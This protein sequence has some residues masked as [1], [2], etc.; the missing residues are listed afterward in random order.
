[1]RNTGLTVVQ[2][3]SEEENHH[4]QKPL[5]FGIIRRLFRYTRAYAL[6]RNTLLV[7]VL[8]RS[9]QLPV[10]TWMIGAIIDGPITGSNLGGTLVAIG[11]F[12][13]FS[14][15]TQFTFVYRQRLALH[16]G[17]SVVHDLRNELFDKM[18]TMPMSFFDRT[19]VGRVISRFTTDTESVRVGVQDTLFVSLV[20]GG[21]MLI[22]AALMLYFDPLLF[23]VVMAVGPAIWRINRFF[24]KRLSKA[25]RDALESWSRVSATVAESVK[26]VKVSQSHARLDVNAALFRDL[27]ADHGVYNMRTGRLT[28]AFLPL[29]EFNSQFFI[30]AL[31]ILGG[32]RVLLPENAMPIG[33]LIQF[34]FLSNLFFGPIQSLAN[35]YNNALTAMVG[36]ER[37]FRFLDAE[38]EW[39]D[40][41]DA[42]SLPELRGDVQFQDVHFAYT[43]D[44]SALNGISFHARQG[45]TVALVGHTG[46]GK[47]T[48]INLISKFYLPTA[49][50]VL[51]DGVDIRELSAGWIHQNLGIVLQQNF[52]FT[53]TVMDNIR[54]GRPGASDEEVVEAVRRLDAMDF[55]AE[56]PEG[57]QTHVGEDGSGISIGQRQVVCFARA[58]L[59]DPRILILDEATSAIDVLTEHRLQHAL[60]RLLQDR[61]SFVIA[62]R[63][64]T[65]RYADLLLMLD[66]G[67]I[68]EKGSHDELM[69][70]DG[71]YAALYRQFIHARK[72]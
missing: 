10:M 6:T 24:R 63:L 69:A 4:A 12:L 30:A 58:M 11:I 68:I 35:Q 46:S 62:H 20:Q 59:V 18:L 5:D 33:N 14:A 71:A 16:L 32:Y 9:A 70:Q 51:I 39:Q 49:G 43:E 67:R 66:Q 38:P 52:L 41:P 25:H 23:L 54:V 7:L 60:D 61:T 2:K 1:M 57:F 27:V 48:I 15:F 44:R 26:G 8:L 21:Q 50:R 29:L 3:L 56:L 47:T 36:A 13:G 55:I 17:E 42:R 34:F 37:V 65:I 40:P 64:S 45:E 22:A 53:G 31:V 72:G 28:A 19:K